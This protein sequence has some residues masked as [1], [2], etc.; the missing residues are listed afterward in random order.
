MSA[1]SQVVLTVDL[2]NKTVSM[3]GKM[4]M[5][6]IVRVVLLNTGTTDVSGVIL[7]VRRPDTQDVVATC[8]GFALVGS[9]I[10]ADL[11]LPEATLL[12][13]F[14]YDSARMERKFALQV[15]DSVAANQSCLVED[16]VYVMNN[17]FTSAVQQETL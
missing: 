3:S 6:E 16:W 5:R 11:E 10:Q 12:D 1:T 15:F 2:R 7:N 13:I 9:D 17:S 4:A 14:K 8:A